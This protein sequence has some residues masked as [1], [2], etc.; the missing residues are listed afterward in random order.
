MNQFRFIPHP[1]SLIPRDCEVSEEMNRVSG[2]A[3]ALGLVAFT[4]CAAGGAR[5]QGGG[6]EAAA[7]AGLT[8]VYRIDPAASP[9]AARI[10]GGILHGTVT[11]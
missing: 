3:R 11:P 9:K 2:F 7:G 8:G 4:L 1:S 6:R 10:R 5:A